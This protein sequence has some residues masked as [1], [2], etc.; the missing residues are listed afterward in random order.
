[1][2]V[3]GWADRQL[4]TVGDFP[5]LVEGQQIWT[6]SQL[7]A[8]SMEVAGGLLEAGL[9]PGQ[10][11]LLQMPNCAHLV[12][13]FSA[14]LRAGGVAVILPPGASSQEV[15]RW[16]HELGA[17]IHLTAEL[18]YGQPL[19][20]PV[21]REEQDPAQICL[22]SGTTGTARAIPWTH[23]QIERRYRRFE[24]QRVP[25]RPRVALG[26]LPFSAS[27]GAQYLYLRWLQKMQLVLLD[28]FDPARVVE[29]VERWGIQTAMLVPSMCEAL[30]ALPQ[31]HLSRLKS[32]LV[33]GSG[34]SPGLVER[35]F[36]R[37][38]IRLTTVYGLTELGPVA[39]S[40]PGGSSQQLDLA[41]SGF[42]ARIVD[43]AGQP[44]AIGE[45][46]QVVL[47]GP[48]C[49]QG[50]H[51]GDLGRLDASGLLHCAGRAQ[52]SILQGGMVL[53]PEPLEELLRACP[54]VAEAAVVG[55]PDAYLGE[56]AVACVVGQA[57]AD[58]VLE[59]LGQQ[60][61]PRRSPGRVRHFSSLPRSP[62]G[63]L[64][65]RELRQLAALPLERAEITS[66][67]QM[68]SLLPSL[69]A[70][71]SGS[72][73]GYQA[74]LSWRELGL[75]SLGA[76]LLANQLGD[77]LAREFP[78]TLL[79]SHP[80]PARL[81]EHL[82][83]R[84]SPVS[85][86]AL[87][88][89]A[90]GDEAL[91]VVGW[92]CR[93]P[94]LAQPDDLWGALLSGID[95]CDEIRRWDMQ[96]LYDAVPG[97]PGKT[98]V[99]RASLLELENLD[100]EFWGL[101]PS[102]ARNL[103]PAHQLVLEVAWEAL[104]RAGYAPRSAAMAD[105][106]VYLGMAPGSLELGRLPSMAVARLGQ[107][108]HLRGPAMVIDT[109]CSSSLAALDTAWRALRQGQCSLALVGGVNLLTSPR[110]WVELSQLRVL[111]PDGRCK[112]FEER[113]DGFGRGEGCVMLV[114]KRL[115]L[116]LADG[117][118][119]LAVIRGSGL[120]HD[121][122]SSSLTAP[123]GEAQ[124]ALM[125]RTLATLGLQPEDLHYQE[126]HGT[127]TLLG[128][129]VEWEALSGLRGGCRQPL[130]IGSV[131]ANF[132]HLET[133][134]GALG[135]LKA[136]LV[137][138]H[139]MVPPQAGFQ[140]LSSRLRGSQLAVVQKAQPL[141]GGGPWRAGVLSLG[142]S[143]T[144]AYAVVESAPPIQDQQEADGEVLLCQSAPTRAS[145][146][147]LQQR[148]EDYP[149]NRNTSFTLSVG[150]HPFRW[151]RAEVGSWEAWG[152]AAPGEVAWLF[153][154]QGS[155]WPQAGL[156]LARH[157]PVLASSLAECERLCPGILQAL[158]C[159]KGS[160]V[161]PAQL[162]L[163]WSLSQLW[164]S[165]GLFPGAVLGHSLGELAAACAAGLWPLEQALALARLRGELMEP[166]AGGMLWVRA[167]AEPL[168]PLLEG[169]VDLA[170]RNGPQDCA[171]SGPREEL[172]QL[173]ARL[174]AAGLQWGWLEVATPFHSRWLEPVL[175]PWAEALHSAG[176]EWGAVNCDFYSAH[177]G[178]KALPEEVRC[179]DYWVH[180]LR[181]SVHFESASRDLLQHHWRALLEIGPHPVLLG[182]VARDCPLP[183]VASMRREAGR[184][185]LLEALGQLYVAGWNP[186]WKAFWK[187]R[188]GR[189][190]QLP[191][192]PFQRDSRRQD[193][194]SVETGLCD[195]MAAVLGCV[196]DPESTLLEQ[197]LDSLR[198]VE[199]V[200]RLQDRFGW[201]L[202]VGQL[203]T[204][205]WTSLIGAQGA[206]GWLQ[207]RSSGQG[208]AW[209][210][211]P[212]AGGQVTAYLKLARCVSAPVW[213]L[214]LEPPLEPHTLPE[215]ARKWARELQAKGLGACRLYGWSL[216]G[217]LAQAT[218]KALEALGV[219]VVAV[220]MVDPPL[221]QE[222]AYLNKEALALAGWLGDF[223]VAG[224]P[225]S[226][227]VAVARLGSQSLQECERRGW[228]Q[229][230]RW[231]P[232]AW[233]RRLQFYGDT[234]EL[235]AGLDPQPLS[236]PLAVGL[237]RE[238]QPSLDLSRWGS[239]KV[240]VCWLG[241]DH[242]SVMQ[243]PR[244]EAFLEV[245]SRL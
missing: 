20:D 99:R 25:R 174:D 173:G 18:P 220:G 163:Q 138:A 83:P 203:A 13:A 211:F 61:G 78:A 222:G 63:K 164:K 85:A 133:A 46:G 149:R 235:L 31:A 12:V 76:V 217:W 91:A 38:G 228:V 6:S 41:G 214:Q 54:G 110:S 79:F 14:V 93:L 118:N 238:P 187:G 27:F 155:L 136:A 227:I 172:E 196:P 160:L 66:R 95:S 111:S 28:H 137:V 165:W 204:S 84:P 73:A 100:R 51:T 234:M 65:R 132:G 231:T 142:M 158:E 3:A 34:V 112:A 191:T 128:D 216:G 107:L 59:H 121:G 162:S 15:S 50:V 209:V 19:G 64:L 37:F 7:H 150:R 5:A 210:C 69:L 151:R 92:S 116:A 17:R 168:Q 87:G 94:A 80:T 183:R 135:L 241:G 26:V 140:R 98:Y 190:V 55:V 16:L 171:V 237:A 74:E 181:H 236:C 72:S 70:R 52:D 113:A 57:T 49:P 141:A 193:Q 117:D 109:S 207:L 97:R 122:L 10:A 145:L 24:E 177:L 43:E 244:F 199:L 22:T 146:H 156:Q 89:I 104:E 4:L 152:R 212:P 108:L 86:A 157:E 114:V 96:R 192:T 77:F 169:K 213:A 62:A 130:W 8:K 56:Q 197:G 106:G 179:P 201:S 240:Q 60:F 2:N 9:T 166:I 120:N 101:S 131:K 225:W 188:E 126:T 245:V 215:L 21:A 11:V 194:A 239:G 35:F 123:N 119:V 229:P 75:D 195:E 103:D 1:M 102:E 33:G 202:D 36:Q 189:R 233:Q 218:A 30:L 200:A 230:G 81:V 205:R 48:E 170:A 53:Y 105:C 45:V 139:G 221:I 226:E 82:F 39:R 184:K 143:G 115:S 185:A 198:A 154:G 153:T 159:G 58:Q 243:S 242:Y 186:D 71:L 47:Y 127:G 182:L 129:A 148:L 147:Y 29:L 23:G 68:E 40:R 180:S 125:Q 88:T 208:A 175:G 90:G 206:G 178:R 161:Q 42:S 44:V 223:A 224:L 134:A 32:L 167:G 219:S 67:D 176:L 232:D 144:N 124:R